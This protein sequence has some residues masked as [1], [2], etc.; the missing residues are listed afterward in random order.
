MEQERNQ[1]TNQNV[2]IDRHDTTARAHDSTKERWVDY[3]SIQFK[4]APQNFLPLASASV[5]LKQRNNTEPQLI[6]SLKVD[7]NH[8]KSFVHFP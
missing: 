2:V 7:P 8:Q 3:A 6:L 5:N 4:C 1:A